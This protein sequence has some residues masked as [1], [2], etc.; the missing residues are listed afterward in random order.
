VDDDQSGKLGVAFDRFLVFGTGGWASGNPSTAFALTGA[1][2]FVT[3]GGK[4]SGWAAGGGV[5]YAITDT[6]LGRVPSSGCV[7]RTLSEMS[8][9][10]AD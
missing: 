1:A 7:R 8:I 4:S 6:I 5:E 3:T 2:P 10:V 9:R